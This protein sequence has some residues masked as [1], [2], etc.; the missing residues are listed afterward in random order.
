MSF[1][2]HI[3]FLASSISVGILLIFGLIITKTNVNQEAEI[4]LHYDE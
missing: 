4:R 3:T 1:L 2:L